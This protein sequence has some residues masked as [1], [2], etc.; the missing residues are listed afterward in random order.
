MS[1]G[2]ARSTAEPQG[3]SRWWLR[4][5]SLLVFIFFYAPIVVLFIF[6]FNDSNA[7]GNW[8][9]FTFGWYEAFLDND[10]VQKSIWVSVK[11]CLFSTVIAVVLGTASAWPWNGSAGGARRPSTP[12]STFRSSSPTSPWP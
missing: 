7:V 2:V 6:S 8:K 10:N 11:V 1:K 12:F 4:G 3:F 5:H 9:G